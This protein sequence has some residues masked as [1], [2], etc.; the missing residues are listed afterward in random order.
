MLEARVH[1]LSL[2]AVEFQ[3]LSNKQCWLESGAVVRAQL[4]INLLAAGQTLWTLSVSLEVSSQ[5]VTSDT[6]SAG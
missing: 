5:S 6:Q 4:L 1:I 3:Y 2:Y